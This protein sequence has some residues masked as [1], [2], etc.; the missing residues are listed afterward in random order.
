MSVREELEQLAAEVHLAVAHQDFAGA[1]ER[2]GVYVQRL[3]D[4]SK[5][6]PAGEAAELVQRASSTLKSARR[7]VCIARALMAERLR[8][9]Q[10]AAGYS[11]RPRA[12]VHTWSVNA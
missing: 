10:R 3:H 11:P 6:L 12:A 8:R 2:A 9:L 5:H 7:K 4:V 1:A